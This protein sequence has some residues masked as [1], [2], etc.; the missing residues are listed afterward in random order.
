MNWARGFHM[1]SI[2][3]INRLCFYPVAL[4]ATQS[5]SLVLYL[6]VPDSDYFAPM[7]VLSGMVIGGTIIGITELVNYFIRRKEQARREND[8]I[9]KYATNPLKTH[10]YV[11][12]ILPD[13]ELVYRFA[14]DAYKNRPNRN[15]PDELVGV[16]HSEFHTPAETA[17]Y[18]KQ[19][20]EIMNTGMAIE[21]ESISRHGRVSIKSLTPYVDV[22]TGRKYIT[23]V[24]SN[25]RDLKETQKKL[26]YE[27]YHD[28]LTALPNR[29]LLYDRINL[30]KASLDRNLHDNKNT[31]YIGLFK[32]DLDNF[33]Y[34]NDTYGHA[35]GDK[36][37]IE[38]AKRLSSCVREMDTVVREGGDEFTLLLPEISKD[39]AGTVAKKIITEINKPYHVDNTEHHL[40]ISIGISLYPLDGTAFDVIHKKAD[41]ALYMAKT[42]GKNKYHV[43]H[44]TGH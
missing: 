1:L 40:G 36:L 41:E 39:G 22:E 21:F 12:E 14:N 10:L 19:L 32:M 5:V 30:A 33:K 18:Y 34:N 35:L 29:R 2:S 20:V 17:A 28:T 24:T 23:A 13:G 8:K 7:S 6:S 4:A 38:V 31:G 43:Y 3:G 27:A 37:L 26:E 42:C 25:I 9:V 16:R 44:E 11:L 15:L